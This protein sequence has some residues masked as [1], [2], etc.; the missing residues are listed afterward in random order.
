[1]TVMHRHAALSK[2]CCSITNPG[3]VGQEL[4]NRNEKK[5]RKKASAP[6]HCNCYNNA[7]CVLYEPLKLAYLHSPVSYL[8]PNVAVDIELY[9]LDE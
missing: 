7:M 3:L 1:M 9:A 2:R 5:K 4:I 8:Y 6:K